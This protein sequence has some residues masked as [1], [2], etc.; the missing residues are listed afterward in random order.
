MAAQRI[1][2]A[3]IFRVLEAAAAEFGFGIMITSNDVNSK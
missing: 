1:L 2:D 3:K